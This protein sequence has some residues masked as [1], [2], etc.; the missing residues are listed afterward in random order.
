MT[1]TS[2]HR[3]AVRRAC[4]F[5]LVVLRAIAWAE[6]AGA[7]VRGM[8]V[9][10]EPTYPYDARAGVD[11]GHGGETGGLTLVA[12]GSIHFAPGNCNRFSVAGAAGFWNPPGPADA[13][14]TT[15]F[16]A[17]LLL[18]PC[19]DPLTVSAITFRFV[20]GAG[21]VRHEDEVAWSAPIGIAAGWKLP[22]PIIHLEPWIVP[23]ALYRERIATGRGVWVGALSAGVNLGIGELFGLRAGVQ[24]CAGG[25]AGGYGLSL[26]F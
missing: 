17:Q 3:I 25:V 15:G 7:Q 16:G 11:L 10:F 6:P 18:N 19:P 2:I 24:C 26:W 23:H 1:D 4:T 20:T 8:P 12:G 22:I 21:L 14:L 13:R 5:A 9:F